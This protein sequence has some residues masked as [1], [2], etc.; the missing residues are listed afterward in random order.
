MPDAAARAAPMQG[1]FLFNV[2]LVFVATVLAYGLAFTAVVVSS[3]ALGPDGKGVTSLYQSGVGLVFALL[4]L[5]VAPATVYF[6]GRRELT[7]QQALEAGLS[8]TIFATAVA[9]VGVGLL[10]LADANGLDL[11]G[12]PYWLAVL[13]VPAVVQ[14]R[15]VESA[16]R[17][18]GRFGAMNALDLIVPAVLVAGWLAVDLTIGLTISR[19]VAVW[20][21]AFL[22]AIVVGYALIGS[23]GWPARPAGR[24]VL[25]KIVPFGLQGQFGNLVQLLNYRLDSY[26]VLLFANASGV[27]L[28]SVGVSLSEGL[29]FIANS[30]ALVFLTNLTSSDE[31]YATQMTPLVCRNTL[32]VTTGACVAA[33]LVS[34]V[35][36]PIV[37]G[38]SFHDAVL[39]FIW[40]MPGTV[41]LAG[42]K[43][44]AAYVFSRGKPMLNGWIALVALVITISVDFVLIP[45]FDVSGAAAGASIGYVVSLVLTAL[46]YRKLSGASIAAAILPRPADASLYIDSARDL[47][48]HLRPAR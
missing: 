20:S 42:T 10:A 12:V 8:V 15:S 26:L 19:A 36:I 4:G 27:G 16:L 11:G 34:P 14:V 37:F 24:S 39:P 30:V 3:R 48:A 43:V 21:F 2:N 38:A 25:A 29:W 31:D 1:R 47:I 28:Y 17:A 6:V 9:A 44:L 18:L 32:L 7:A 23:A 40:L 41:A 35:I 5:G 46:A 13:A 45:L 22:P 33:A